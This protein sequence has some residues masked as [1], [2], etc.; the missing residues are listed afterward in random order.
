MLAAAGLG[1]GTCWIGY[2][3]RYLETAAG[4]ALVGLPDDVLPVAPIV[5]GHPNVMP[6]PTDRREPVIR[7][8][9]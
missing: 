4:R 1:L 9:G 7:W 3:Q 2:T 5:V 6:G 8:L